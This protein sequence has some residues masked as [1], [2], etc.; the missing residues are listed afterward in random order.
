MAPH[1]RTYF[2]NPML[3]AMVQNGGGQVLLLMLLVIREPL[4]VEVEDVAR[5]DVAAVGDAVVAN[6][7]ILFLIAYKKVFRCIFA[8]NLF[9]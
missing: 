6:A 3:R 1:S 7:P 5:E 2:T 4:A 9:R 8:R